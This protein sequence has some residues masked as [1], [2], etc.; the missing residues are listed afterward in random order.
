MKK[1]IICFLLIS[2]VFQ[3]TSN[4]WIMSSFYLNQDYIAKNLCVNRFDKIPVCNGKC[5][6]SNQL[7]ENEK[8]EQKIPNVKE[9]EVQLF[10]NQTSLE[11]FSFEIFEFTHKKTPFFKEFSIVQPPHN[12]VFQP[13]KLV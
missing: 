10:C 9:K 4:F 3:S 7:K 5:Y 1:G 2:F 6:L 13:P 8:K 11:N 12:S